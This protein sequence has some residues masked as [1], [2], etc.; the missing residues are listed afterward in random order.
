MKTLKTIWRYLL[1]YASVGF[2]FALYS[3][4]LDLLFYRIEYGNEANYRFE[5]L[6]YVLY[7][8]IGYL[9]PAL[10]ISIVYNLVMSSV[11]MKIYLRLIIG[12]LVGI[13]IG[14]LIERSGVSY[15]IGHYRPL[16]NII[17]FGL[18]GVSVEVLR[19]I[20]SRYVRH[21][22]INKSMGTT[23]PGI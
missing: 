7:F 18:I 20:K 14:F 22:S 15:Y 2:F 21:S 4:L 6:S 5:L 8:V 19:I 3:S 12:L 13:S 17:L 11:F 23:A 16:K 10:L 9:F 1:F